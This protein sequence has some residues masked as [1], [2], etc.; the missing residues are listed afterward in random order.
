MTSRTQTSRFE[1]TLTRNLNELARAILNW[2]ALKGLEAADPLVSID[3]VLLAYWA[4]FN[5]A[6]AHAMRAFDEHRGAASFWYLYSCEPSELDQ[7]A[8]MVGIEIAEIRS[9][10]KSLKLIRNKTHF[11]IDKKAVFDPT[12]VWQRAS[13]KGADFER[14]VRSTFDVLN[15]LYRTRWRND[16]WLPDYDG[17]DARAIAEFA[18]SLRV[19]SWMAGPRHDGGC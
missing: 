19:K 4:L 16:F 18:E 17:A 1:R 7:A 8:G 5:E 6:F 3:F 14:L 12:A 13:I 2:R 10:S 11:H 9:F 15:F